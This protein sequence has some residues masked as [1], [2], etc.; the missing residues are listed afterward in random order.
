MQFESLI[1]FFAMGGYGL[2]VWLSFG[3][4]F[5]LMVFMLILA[6]LDSQGLAKKVKSEALRKEQVLQAQEKRKLRESKT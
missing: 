2:F 3:V 1:D 6:V 5:G 4:S